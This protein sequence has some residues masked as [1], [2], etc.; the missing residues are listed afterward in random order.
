[1][2]FVLL[3]VLAEVLVWLN[4]LRFSPWLPSGC[5]VLSVLLAFAMQGVSAKM[6]V[7]HLAAGVSRPEILSMCAIFFLSSA[8]HALALKA[9]VV[10]LM[11]GFVVS[12]VPPRL[13]LCAFFML[14]ALTSW[15][16]GSSMAVVATVL[17]AA[18]AV[19]Q[20]CGADA[21]LGAGTVRGAMFGDN[22]SPVSDTSIAAVKSQAG[23][24]RGSCTIMQWWH[25]RQR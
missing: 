17:P 6:A 14:S 8:M 23:T 13:L 20:Q 21:A 16:L 25:C 10:N 15:V 24:V 5:L 22:L 7:R 12:S 18:F 19:S 1:M 9:Q 3:F 11:S 2:V 4:G